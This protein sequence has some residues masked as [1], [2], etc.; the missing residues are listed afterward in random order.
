[1]TRLPL[2]APESGFAACA[3]VHR[4]FL[5]LPLRPQRWRHD[6]LAIQMSSLGRCDIHLLSAWDGLPGFAGN[7]KARRR[8]AFFY[9]LRLSSPRS[10]G[11]AGGLRATRIPAPCTIVGAS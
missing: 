3:Y 11:P 10:N 7:K 1:M 4:G 9:R 5:W 8:R 6:G 2:Y